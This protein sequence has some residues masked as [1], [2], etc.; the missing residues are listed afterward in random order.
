MKIKS[1][2]TKL[3]SVTLL[4]I[5]ILA[6]GLMFVM[7][8]FMNSLTD[9]IMLNM[10]QPMAKTAAQ[11]VEGNLHTLADRFFLI[12]D[13]DVFIASDATTKEKQAVLNKATSGIEFVWLGIYESDG[14]LLTGSSDCPRNISGREL[15][16]LMRKTTNLVIEDTSIGTSGLE[17][18]MGVP[19]LYAWARDAAPDKTDRVAY[20]LVGSYKYDVLGD[21][22]RNINIGTNGTAFIINQDGALMAHKDL[23]KVFSQES[24]TNSLGSST[25]AQNVLLSMKQGQTGSADID[26]SN[27][28]IF[29]SYSPVR[30]TLW[31][32]GIQ[33]PH[34]DFTAAA[35]Q[36]FLIGAL[37]TLGSLIFFAI[38][39][40]VFTR[41]ILS[42]PLRAITK[43]A[44]NLAMGQFDDKLPNN[45]TDRNDEIG[46]LG[47]AFV[48][49]SNS[50]RA[51]IH[52]IGQLTVAARKGLL[53]KRADHVEYHGDYHL[54][55]AGMNATLDVVCS[56][57]DSMP[58]ALMLF[59][60]S[61]E[62]VYLNHAM[63]DIMARHGFDTDNKFLLASILSSNTS[64]RL[65]PEAARVFSLEGN[66]GGLYNAD[67][68]IPDTKG[69]GFNYRLSLGRVGESAGFAESAVVDVV[70]VM[71]ILNDVTM[72]TKAKVDAEA[73]SRAKGDFLSRMSH[74]MRTPMNAIIGMATIGKASNDIER[75]EYTLVKIGE[76]SQH[77]LGVINDILDMSKIEADKFELSFS[78]F[79][80][81]KMLQ[82]VTNVINF[83]V[84]E[85]AQ[86]LFIQIDKDIPRRI[87]SDEQRLT[88]VITNLLS[89]AVKF[90][91]EEGSITLKADKISENET[92]CTIRVEVKDTGIGITEEQQK[93][94]FTSFEQAD[95]S[96]SR[97]FGGTGLGLAISKRLLEMMSGRIWIESE[98]GQGTS[99]IF[100]IDAPKG[101]PEPNY[102]LQQDIDW[103]NLRVL[104]VDDAP[105]IL[106]LFK[107]MLAP[108]GVTCETATSG[109]EA[110][111]LV[112]QNSGNPFDLI[113]VD[114]RMPGM[115]GIEL[116]E[117][118]MRQGASKPVI[119][120]ITAA[121]WSGIEKEARAVGVSHFLA[122]PLFPSLLV[123]CINECMTHQQRT[124]DTSPDDVF[125]E[126]IFSGKLVLL[127]E[128]VEINREILMTLIEHTGIEI[129]SAADGAEAV[130]KF[131]AHP[132][133]YEL[134]LMDVHM[135]NVDGYEATRRI[136]ASGLP[137]ADTIPIIA[138]TA[139]VFRED[140][141]RCLASGMNDHLGKPID[142][143]EVITTLRRYL[144]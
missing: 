11:S 90:T 12:R 136:R 104:A 84:E 78:E 101:D 64:D 96:I 22:L 110:F 102:L 53:S 93:R 95:G 86:N 103:K 139:N 137:G 45:L 16:P 107:S 69:D 134:I 105:E 82:R 123:D 81:E 23:G 73:A 83:R 106:D 124:Y 66:G 2:T 115:D 7:M 36:A 99:F 5:A 20:Y 41:K 4:V 25:A 74:E 1:V 29:V 75:K 44:G 100:T 21:V 112:E 40:S 128:D 43:S 57:L 34:D 35:K 54:I 91:P 125:A 51:V 142:V 17:I 55:V 116:T 119:V 19:V 56:H 131:S 85:K 111:S 77:L 130:D 38:I 94:L 30:G 121:D 13:N 122:K 88:Q 144:L 48:T 47:R 46:Q 26:G 24:I 109:Y 18:V 118:I 87:I 133:K 127:A 140:I 89:N 120:L 65:S 50:I 28:Q 39:L 60:E 72:L 143:A 71:L 138:M 61:Q 58:G 135:P 33:A 31:S 132:D 6:A 3:L 49:M 80:F 141:E 37:I 97:K 108:Y 113:F 68:T 10:L 63:Q 8:Y 76:A 52:D 59:N 70:C 15:Y 114:W 117:K 9:T 14:S 62:P 42:A 129:D 79:N 67:V 32:L 92:T 126:G 98:P 27:G